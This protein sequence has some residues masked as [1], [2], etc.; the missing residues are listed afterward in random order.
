MGNMY[1]IQLCHDQDPESHLTCASHPAALTLNMHTLLSICQ[2]LRALNKYKTLTLLTL[3]QISDF[4]TAYL[5]SRLIK[6]EL[7]LT[8]I[9]LRYMSLEYFAIQIWASG[10]VRSVEKQRGGGHP[11]GLCKE[12]VQ[13]GYKNEY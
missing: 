5:P 4:R 13:L 7:P 10:R 12:D 8:R 9:L 2:S 6:N 1:H 3:T 11:A